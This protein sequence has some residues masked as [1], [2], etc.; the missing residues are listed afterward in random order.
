LGAN[1]LQKKSSGEIWGSN[2]QPGAIPALE[3]ILSDI[4]RPYMRDV[5]HLHG[6][7]L[8]MLADHL[9]K[10]KLHPWLWVYGTC[11][12][13]IARKAFIIAYIFRKTLIMVCGPL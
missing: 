5:T 9:K 10:I 12:N 3:Q 8:F 11:P 1:S 13:D 4:N 2:N 7:Q 6:L